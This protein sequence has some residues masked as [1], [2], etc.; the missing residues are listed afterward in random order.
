MKT[1][2]TLIMVMGILALSPYANGQKAELNVA[3]S[4]ITWT[5][6]KVT[7]SHTGNI[8][9][10]SGY[11]VKSGDEF[12][13][14][15]FV[16]DMTSISNADIEDPDTKAK[17]VGHLKSDDFFSVDKFPT[18]ILEINSG[19][20]RPGGG[21]YIFKG[22]MTIKENTNP[23]SFEATSKDKTFVGT[24]TVDRSKY[25]VRYGSDSFFDNLGDNMI[26]DDFDLEFVVTLK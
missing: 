12:V 13:S 22:K 21:A 2:F 15:K 8:N 10:L 1:L 23:V 4:N 14:G 9:L 11:L 17:L 16:V 24:L 25:N 26:Y 5:G 7:G 18:A 6:K 20:K 3:E 19:E